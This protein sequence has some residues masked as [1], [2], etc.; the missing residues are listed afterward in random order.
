MEKAVLILNDRIL[1]T[2]NSKNA[3]LPPMIL[4]WE[5]YHMSFEKAS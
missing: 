2:G 4:R 3:P 5:N 1:L